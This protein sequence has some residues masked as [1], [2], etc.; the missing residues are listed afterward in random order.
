MF[1][2]LGVRIERARPTGDDAQIVFPEAKLLTFLAALFAARSEIYGITIDG[3]RT[4]HDGVGPGAKFHEQFLIGLAGER[5]EHTVRR[6]NFAIG[7]DGE[8]YVNEGQVHGWAIE[9]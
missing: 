4:G 3:A 2:D 5:F 8:V 9:N 1:E 7:S 6:S